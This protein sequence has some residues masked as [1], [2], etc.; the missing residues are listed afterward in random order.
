MPLCLQVEQ[1]NRQGEGKRSGQDEGTRSTLANQSAPEGRAEM[2]PKKIE[3]AGRM[4]TAF[5]AAS[6]ALAIRDDIVTAAYLRELEAGQ[7]AS[8]QLWERPASGRPEGPACPRPEAGRTQR[9]GLL[10]GSMAGT[11]MF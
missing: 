11:F 4:E 5:V 10:A 6:D 8:G 7:P 2:T 3:L 9:A 1:A